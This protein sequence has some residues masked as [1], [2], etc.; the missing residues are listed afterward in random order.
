MHG[1]GAAASLT[2]ALQ[3]LLERSRI[4]VASE[5]A[6][7]ATPALLRGFE[8]AV[9]VNAPTARRVLA[10]GGAGAGAPQAAALHVTL[11]PPED[12]YPPPYCC[13]YPCPYCT[14]PL[15][16]DALGDAS[17]GHPNIRVR[18]HEGRGVSD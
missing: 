4:G 9:L 13:P 15:L 3:Q 10:L 2:A 14:L 17:D 7:A 1:L 12:G 5:A 11:P 8:L 18:V 16:M 6:L